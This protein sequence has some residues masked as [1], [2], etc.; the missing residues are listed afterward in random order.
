MPV[1]QLTKA[2]AKLML[3]HPYF[4]T[5]LV[6]L[7]LTPE[8]RIATTQYGT[9][10]L[11]YNPEYLE[12]L[13]TEETMSILAHA[14]MTQALYHT[15][16]SGSRRDRIWQIASSYAIND[17]LVQNGF[18]LPP[19]AHYS[20]R[21]ERLY[22]EQ[23]YAMLLSEDADNTEETEE[24]TTGEL[25]DTSVGEILL[26][27]NDYALLIEQVIAK[28]EKQGAL[29]R[30]LERLIPQAK[31]PQL[32]WRELL[33]RYVT[34]HA[35]SDYRMFPSN[36]KHLYRGVALP[37]VYG[38]ELRIA[39][40]VD[41]SASVEEEM[42]GLF[43]AELEGIMQLFPHYTI[44][45]IECDAKI[46]HL[47]TLTPIE[48]LVATLHG[49]GGTDF[50]PVFTYLEEAGAQWRFLIYFTD[51][52]GHYPDTVPAIDTLWVLSQA[53]EVPFGERVVIEKT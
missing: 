6:A 30:G 38:E 3:E 26:M 5:M 28:L 19:M 53:R 16:R 51:G 32:S 25:T 9:D 22:T 14:A 41:T 40:A 1:A 2:K 21:F 4:A 44:E 43:L 52:E 36:K 10:R 50:R 31:S 34:S 20:S 35:R 27:D 45:L 23:I 46:Q 24:E 15:Q 12:V 49:G 29:P 11:S 37:S 33:Y 47:Q 17:L 7:E 48:P 39:V 18:S 13:T 42:L 8:T